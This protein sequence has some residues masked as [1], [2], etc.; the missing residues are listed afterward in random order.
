MAK[1][2]IVTVLY[3]SASVLEEYFKSLNNQT[4]KD[5]T[6]YIIDNNSQDES[7]NVAKSLSKEVSFK[8]IFVE[9][10]K[11]WGVAK[12][13][14]IGIKSALNDGCDY[15]ILSNN[16]VVLD[17]KDTLDI[18]ANKMLK[19]NIDILCTKIKYYYDI[20]YL[21]SWRHFY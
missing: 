9:E 14:N 7:L 15:I 18:L 19:S 13:N 11:N 16:D 4:F 17:N 5:F 20:N 10:K 21:G 3:N 6:V 8:C 2:G 1:I 12:G